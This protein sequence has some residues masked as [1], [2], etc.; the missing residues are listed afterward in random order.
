MMDIPMLHKDIKLSDNRHLTYYKNG[1]G[2]QLVVLEAGLGMSGHYWVP[3]ITH[4]IDHCQVIAYDR[5]GIGKSTPD[6]SIRD[7]HKLASD[8]IELIEQ[9]HY[10][11]LVLVGHSYGAPIVR[12]ASHLLKSSSHKLKGMV[13][14]DPS[15]EHLLSDY[16][17]ISMFFQRISLP[18]LAR[19]KQLRRI[20]TPILNGFS[21]PIKE[22]VL[23][24]SSS[25]SAARE[26]SLELKSFRA[27]LKE[28]ENL[29]HTP[30]VPVTIITGNQA[31][32]GETEPM[33]KKI[34]EAH[35]LSVQKLNDG[36][37]ILAEHS[38][39]TIPITEPEVIA[40]AV[41]E[42]IEENPL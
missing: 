20:Y 23:K 4:L 6:T 10:D 18:I 14:V 34:K 41:L 13:W 5:A 9:Q 35:Q 30:Q 39:H 8:L 15:D 21:E 32:V 25:L 28:L 24:D 7:L 37:L 17:P 29:V 11:S 26:A 1:T 3:T 38:G 42:L 22:R 31:M 16:H 19:C 2:K 40:N 33:R 27:G 36:K 12:M